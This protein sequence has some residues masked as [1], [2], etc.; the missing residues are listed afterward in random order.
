M[1]HSSR[2]PYIAVV[3]PPEY[4]RA[5]R[6]ADELD[7]L[8]YE[9]V[10]IDTPRRAERALDA[11][12]CVVVLT[13]DGW[14][15]PAIVAVLRSRPPLL[16]PVLAAP[17]DLPNARWS[18]EPI[19]MRGSSR[20]V[21]EEVADA[22]DA[23]MR[24]GS[25]RSRSS[26]GDRSNSGDRSSGGDRRG[27]SY[28]PSSR[29]RSDDGRDGP[30]PS[31]SSRPRGGYD[32]EREARP[33]R[34][35]AGYD[36]EREARP[37][38]PR[39]ASAGERGPRASYPPGGAAGAKLNAFGEP[40]K[41]VAAAPAVAAKKGTSPGKVFGIIGVL[42]VVLGG[43][44][45]GGYSFRH[46]LFSHAATT[47][48][49]PQPYSAAVP[50]P[51]CDKGNGQWSL[52][53]DSS[54]FTTTCEAS[55]LLVKQT[56]NF[57]SSAEVYFAGTGLGLPQSY[58]V[59]VTA[60]IT[61]G[62]ALTGV[63]LIVHGQSP[64]GGHVFLALA[65]SLWEF[66]VLN[67]DNKST[68]GKR[69]GFLAAPT[70]TFT[71]DV[72]VVG[73]TM[74]FTINGK[75]VTNVTETSFNNSANIGFFVDSADSKPVA[76][77]F[78][79]FHYTPLPDPTLSTNDAVATAVAVNSAIP[80]PYTAAV[81]GPGCDK[82]GAQW[83][84]PSIYGETGGKFTCTSSG[85][86]I[87][88]NAGAG[89]DV[90]YYGVHGY[91]PTDYTV[92]VTLTPGDQV[93]CGGIYT[94]ASAAGGYAYDVCGNGAYQILELKAG[95]PATTLASGGIGSLGNAPY[96]LKVVESG[97]S[98]TLS[99]NGLALPTFSNKDLPDTD[100]IT[101]F[102]LGT[103]GNATTVSFNGFSFAS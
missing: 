23:A 12:V 20:A 27:A 65:D 11:D 79:Q 82:G 48:A 67:S 35:R 61:S 93:S 26:A 80:N 18:D 1:P 51:T 9:T 3:S 74:T 92:T 70:K 32:D 37:S 34:P 52:P 49:G 71:L 86:Q 98:H 59:Q 16:I 85:L 5:G 42:L 78:S 76:A 94:H 97:A 81:P 100:H 63:G 53:K 7:A 66:A 15:D 14:R 21:A 29:S 90:G 2:T 95:Q 39:G 88:A 69:R 4:G 84:G 91:L 6:L 45:Y 54:Y 58:D 46:K 102:A 64:A 8:G 99:V 96:T 56:T 72:K 40:I 55:D 50:G 31:R 41:P 28:P 24:A 89:T 68:V 47:A 101:L 36:D 75:Q 73:P 43:L 13:P 10:I 83:A 22:V 33:S 62:D 25:S 103:S 19:T 44:G 57:A 77:Q 60:N 17:M 30:E 38:R 87:Q